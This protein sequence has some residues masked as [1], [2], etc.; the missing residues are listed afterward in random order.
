MFVDESHVLVCHYS[1]W[2]HSFLVTLPIKDSNIFIILLNT[3]N[4]VQQ[5]WYWVSPRPGLWESWQHMLPPL[6]I[7]ILESPLERGHHAIINRSPNCWPDSQHKLPVLKV[8]HPTCSSS[9]KPSWIYTGQ[10]DC[11]DDTSK[12]K[13][14][15]RMMTVVKPPIWGLVY[16]TVN[17]RSKCLD[18]ILCIFQPTERETVL[19]IHHHI[20]KA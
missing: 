18:S 17:F 1:K 11:P 4:A 6:G 9:M 14:S 19:F 15:C 16:Y 12:P 3:R 13:K 10:E 20:S 5:K 2:G 8:S 7:F